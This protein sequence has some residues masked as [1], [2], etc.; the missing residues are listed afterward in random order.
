MDG[1]GVAL[2]VGGM[3][4]GR[5]RGPGPLAGAWVDWLGEPPTPAGVASQARGLAGA[6]HLPPLPTVLH[7]SERGALGSSVGPAGGLIGSLAAARA[8]LTA[9]SRGR[10]AGAFRGEVFAMARCGSS[11]PSSW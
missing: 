10:G 2:E 7:P 5:P 11:S 8:L 6:A 3:L 1:D 9:S 4:P